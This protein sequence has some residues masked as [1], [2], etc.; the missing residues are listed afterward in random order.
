M[1]N[2]RITLPEVSAAASNIRSINASMDDYI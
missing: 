1:D 2:I